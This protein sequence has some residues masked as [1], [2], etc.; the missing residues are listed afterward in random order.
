M[1]NKLLTRSNKNKY[2]W[3][4][5]Y[6]SW[7]KVN[8]VAQD[9]DKQVISDKTGKARPGTDGRELLYDQD[10]VLFASEKCSYPLIAFLL[11]SAAIKKKPL[12]VLDFKGTLSGTYAQIK[13]FLAEDVCASWNIIEQEY[14]QSGPVNFEDKKFKFYSSISECLEEK[15]I[16]FVL[17]SNSVQYLKHPHV[18]L[19]KLAAYHF[20]FI[21]FDRTPFNSISSDRLT[22]QVAPTDVYPASH[23]S[24]FFHEDFFLS[25]FSSGYRIVAEF[26]TYID[27]ESLVHIDHKPQGVY[28]GFFL[29]NSLKYA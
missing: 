17:L 20:D 5:D 29:I 22:L 16:D 24:W 25:H 13:D 2:G 18:F 7:D 10:S 21:L 4:G 19:Q 23:P 8:S 15:S 28:K 14:T 26:P 3:F 9:Y 11:M 1:L 27:G 6:S 12:N